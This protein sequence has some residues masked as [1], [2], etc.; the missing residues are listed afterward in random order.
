MSVQI[1][2]N[3]CGIKLFCTNKSMGAAGV[4][5]QKLGFVFKMPFL[6]TGRSECLFFCTKECGKSYFRREIPNN[7]E[8]SEMLRELKEK[9][10]ELSKDVC[11]KISD[12]QNKIKQIKR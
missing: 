10:P 4:E 6:F 3:E 5:A 9:V 8:A 7:K 2:C 11:G 1:V 12:F